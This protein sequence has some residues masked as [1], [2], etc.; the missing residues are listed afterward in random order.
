MKNVINKIFF[1]KTYFKKILKTSSLLVAC[2]CLSTLDAYAQLSSSHQSGT[3]AFSGQHAG[4][5][6]DGKFERW[7]ATLV[8]PPQSNPKINATFYME[9]AKTGDSIYDSTLPEFDWFDVENHALGK[10]VSTKI[11]VT[12]GGYQVIGS[13]TIKD[14]S[15][16]VSFMLTDNKDNLSTSFGINRLEYKIGVE[17]D[18][19]AEWVDKT[20]SISML[21]NK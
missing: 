2:I 9:S 20:I 16:E 11:V 5:D 10:F 14:I 17:S 21:I 7:Q 6:F 13:L 8:L 12:E 19:E 15:K 1:D 4:M 18:P 3:V